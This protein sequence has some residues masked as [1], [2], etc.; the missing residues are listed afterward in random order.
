MTRL[1]RTPWWAYLVAVL[2]LCGVVVLISNPDRSGV[3]LSVTPVPVSRLSLQSTE[4]L[5][6]AH[7][8]SKEAAAA[9]ATN[10]PTF[11]PTVLIVDATDTAIP[12]APLI[13]TPPRILTQST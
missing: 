2:G 13:D 8:V 4:A 3:G 12:P 9:R 11:E 10:K 6:T 5:V 7:P 1:R